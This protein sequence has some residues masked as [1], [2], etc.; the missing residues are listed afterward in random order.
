LGAGSAAGRS[1]LKATIRR[2]RPT[3]SQVPR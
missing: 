1:T 2:G 3:I